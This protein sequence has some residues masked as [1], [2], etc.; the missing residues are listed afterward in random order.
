[1]KLIL[2]GFHVSGSMNAANV[3]ACKNVPFLPEFKS[4]PPDAGEMQNLESEFKEK[5]ERVCAHGI[6]EQYGFNN[7]KNDHLDPVIFGSMG[8]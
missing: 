5:E 3:W 4:C 8:L 2:R 1:M 7:A 6:N